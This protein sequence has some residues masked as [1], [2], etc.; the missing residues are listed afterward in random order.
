[1]QSCEPLTFRSKAEQ[2]GADDSEIKTGTFMSNR[3][4][5]SYHRGMVSLFKPSILFVN[6]I[7]DIPSLPLLSRFL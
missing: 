3:S 7:E 1:V 4:F 5:R 2:A 6:E